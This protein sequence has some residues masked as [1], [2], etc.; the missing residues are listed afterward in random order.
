MQGKID[1]IDKHLLFNRYVTKGGRISKWGTINIL[2]RSVIESGG[3][4]GLKCY[5][6][7][8]FPYKERKYI[9]VIRSDLKGIEIFSGKKQTFVDFIPCKKIFTMNKRIKVVNPD[10]YL[11]SIKNTKSYNQKL[12]QDLHQAKIGEKP[13]ILDNSSFVQVSRKLKG[14]KLV[15]LHHSYKHHKVFTQRGKRVY[16]Q[17]SCPLSFAKW[18]PESYPAQFSG[19]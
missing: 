18:E 2:D 15:A 3:D 4:E 10:G 17:V 16:C 19:E 14:R 11:L 5:S 13:C 9:A 8:F 7:D 12:S 1:S 6:F